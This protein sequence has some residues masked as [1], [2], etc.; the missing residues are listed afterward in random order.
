MGSH[1]QGFDNENWTT[2]KKRLSF[3]QI[4]KSDSEAHFSFVPDSSVTVMSKELD[5]IL[6]QFSRESR[7]NT[8]ALRKLL[9][10]IFPN[11]K[12]YIR[13]KTGMITYSQP[14]KSDW[15]FALSLH[16]K[17]VTLIFGNGA[18]LADPSGVL[19]GKGKEARHVKTKS[20]VETQNSALRQLLED[21][22]KQSSSE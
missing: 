19:S 21:A 6:A 15:V 13:P 18:Q 11:A 20:E 12:E 3:S 14:G 9:F 8:L 22:V 4:W 1:C 10:E 2:T 7:E 16:M 17:H 5:A